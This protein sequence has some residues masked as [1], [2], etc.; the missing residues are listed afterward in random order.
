MYLRTN[1]RL[2]LDD[3]ETQYLTTAQLLNVSGSTSNLQTQINSKTDSLALDT[4]TNNLAQNITTQ[5][6]SCVTNLYFDNA[7]TIYCNSS[8]TKSITPFQLGCVYGAS[9]NF[10]DQISDNLSTL[11]N[12]INLRISS[13]TLTGSLTLYDTSAVID[14]K[15]SNTMKYDTIR[16]DSINKVVNV[17]GLSSLSFDTYY[18]SDGIYKK[19]LLYDIS[20]SGS[21]TRNTLFS[22]YLRS[23]NLWVEGNLRMNPGILYLDNPLNSSTITTTNLSYLANS[24][25]NLQTQI[26]LK[27]A[28]FL[29]AARIFA[30]AT[31]SVNAGQ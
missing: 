11:T 25:S 22:K 15:L 14:T 7:T 16:S 23:N 21:Y 29:Y 26:D 8:R 9:S 18:V 17:T 1:S 30:N 31:I 4:L 28:K 5:T 12:A 6:I 2:Y 24:T 10:Q 13:A 3:L 27:Q 20:N 19:D